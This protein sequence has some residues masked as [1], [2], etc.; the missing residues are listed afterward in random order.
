MAPLPEPEDSAGLLK[1]QVSLNG[2]NASPKL[3][4][5]YYMHP[6]QNPVPNE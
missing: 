2:S 6:L 5:V 4:L 3:S 1:F